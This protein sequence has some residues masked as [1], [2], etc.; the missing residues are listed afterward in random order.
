MFQVLWPPVTRFPST[1]L[2]R[3]LFGLEEVPLLS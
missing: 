2:G 1:M 3:L